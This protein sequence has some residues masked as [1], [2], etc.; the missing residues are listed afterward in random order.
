MVVP[1]FKTEYLSII[2]EFDGNPNLL[3]EF[4]TSSELLISH[5]YDAE[6]AGSFQNILLVKSVKN[7]IIGEAANNIA[8]YSISSWQDLKEALLASYED[9]RDHYSLILELCAMKQN[10]LKPL[11]F[12][13]KIQNN[14]NLQTS[15]VKLHF[16]E[17]ESNIL[18]A[19]SQKL[20]LRVLLKNLNNPLGDYLSTRNPSSL[21][22]AL[23]ILTNDFN[24]NEN[25]LT[26]FTKPKPFMAQNNQ[27]QK[28][29]FP[30]KNEPN[31]FKSD[32]NFVPAY[33]PTP[34]STSTKNTQPS[35]NKF[36][37]RNNYPSNRNYFVNQSNQKPNWV[38]EE[39]YNTETQDQG[40]FLEK[41]ASEINEWNA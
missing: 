22:E 40:T 18:I 8:S 11:D 1:P 21:N 20:A 16:A 30:L 27:F 37:P 6:N 36:Q 12:L 23:N 32:K 28:K 38:S 29:N 26:T 31:V 10:N 5:F 24:I 19:H 4:I 34:M 15:Y 39:L 17:D 41:D 33:K 7:K 9:K 2:P 14:L 35:R 25:K 3:N 13:N